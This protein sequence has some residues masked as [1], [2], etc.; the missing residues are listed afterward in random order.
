MEISRGV[1]GHDPRGNFEMYPLGNAISSVMRANLSCFQIAL[2][3]SSFC[4]N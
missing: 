3:S 1:R 2:K 4:A